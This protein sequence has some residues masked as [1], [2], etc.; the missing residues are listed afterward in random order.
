MK[1]AAS[2]EKPREGDWVPSRRQAAFLAS[3]A[4][5][6]LYGGA[7]SGGK[8]EA[9]V[10]GALRWVK[11]AGFRALI[12]RRTF[13]ELKRDII[14]LSHEYYPSEGGVYHVGEKE[15]RFPS[16]AV[17]EFGHMEHETDV[18]GYQGLEV[19]YLAFDELTSFTEYQYRY[20]LSRLRTSKG[21][22]LRVRAGTN[23]GGEGHEWVFKRWAPWLDPKHPERVAPG[24]LLYYTN[25]NDGEV[26]VDKN[27]RTELGLPP[28]SRQFV[29]ARITD[30]PHVDKG[31]HQ[32]LMGQDALTRAQLLDGDWL[33][34]AAPGL[35][36]RRGW[37]HF[38]D[39][40]P[41][42]S[43]IRVRRWDL[44]S[45][46]DGGDWTVG[47]LMT[48]DGDGRVLIEDVQRARLRPSGVESLVRAT[49]ELDNRRGP[50]E[51]WIPQDPGQ[52]GKAQCEAYARLLG[53][54]DV[55]FKTETGDKVTRSKPFSAQCEAGN[56]TLVRALWNE[57]FMQ[58]LEA[59]PEGTHDDDV[60][61][62][63]GAYVQVVEAT[64]LAQQ[65]KAYASK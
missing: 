48:S 25:T 1:M 30:N 62:A 53:G 36:F 44:A 5:E 6:S 14:P 11:Q 24:A 15:W 31:Y 10:I 35:L 60:D 43:S 38:V 56:V 55:R 40:P 39:V 7:A 21:L 57:P 37:F 22:P 26:Y 61:A 20:L 32:R 13:P 4:Y 2:A 28:L 65:L 17:I 54:F 19:Q 34:K 42:R 47:V 18:H 16:G 12:L 41:A 46:E 27:Y 58:C 8:T 51:I 45:T 52:A 23:P 49:A 29:P 9:L 63:S 64:P 50:T 59:F 3:T 33:A